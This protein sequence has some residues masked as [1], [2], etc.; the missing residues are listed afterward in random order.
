[1]ITRK[2]AP[3]LAAGCTIVVKPP[4]LTP[5]SSLALAQL[6]SEVGIPDGVINILPTTDSKTVGEILATSKQVRK[7]SF[8]GSTG[9]GKIL[10]KQCAENVKKISLELGGNAPFIVFDDADLDAAAEQLMACKF[11]NGGQTCISANRVL[12]QD[13]VKEEFI[14]KVVS[15]VKALN[16]GP[17]DKEDVDLG[18]LIDQD[19]VDKVQRLVISAKSDGAEIEEGGSV[20]TDLGD[21]FYAP[22]V[23]SGVTQD[24]E[25]TQEE[26]FGPVIAISSFETEEEAIQQA[27]DTPF[28]LAS[29]F[30]A[31]DT[32]RIFRVSEGLEYGM[33]GVNTG[34]I[35]H[36]YNPFGGIKESGIGREGSKYGIDEYLEIKTITLGGLE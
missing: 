27:N 6:A 23:I 1:M 5:L 32:A 29:Y 35:S 14:K 13:S 8:T 16:V 4:Q 25:I 26:I 7:L 31:K 10:M 36:A 22:T 15:K 20:M 9:V 33:V 18:P 34:A 12:V 17:G 19:A 3:A 28:G 21:L 11:R 2:V 30:A 24:M